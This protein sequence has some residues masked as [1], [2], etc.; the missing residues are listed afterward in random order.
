MKSFL[1]TGLATLLLSSGSVYALDPVQG[2]YA[3]IFL[4]TSKARSVNISAAIPTYNTYGTGQL[5]YSWF[6][7]IG[8]QVGYRMDQF[9]VEAELS[10]NDSPYNSLVFNGVINSIPINGIT[11]PK[12]G[13]PKHNV[14]A[15]GFQMK[16]QTDIAA[17][18]FNGYYDN[19]TLF[20]QTCFV[21]YIGIGI[22]YASV[23]N[24]IQFYY[25]NTP[26]TGAD[27]SERRNA[28]AGQAIIGTNYFMDD[29]TSFGLDFRYLSTAGIASSNSSLVSANNVRYQYMA[30]NLTFNGS[31]DA[32]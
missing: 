1:K 15:T 11:I 22:G 27:F 8:G 6:G 26:I 17:L 3:G 13:N 4:G 20:D 14:N 24:K 2:I 28:F 16:G 30:V 10:Y 32:G 18:M 21:P 7:D 19:Y 23:L 25:S 5:N 31:F 9:R 12:L 29:F